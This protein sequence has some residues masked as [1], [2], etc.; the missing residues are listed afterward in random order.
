[1]ASVFRSVN[2]F[3]EKIRKTL[4]FFAGPATRKEQSTETC[5]EER[6]QD[7]APRL[8]PIKPFLRKISVFYSQAIRNNLSCYIGILY[9]MPTGAFIVRNLAKPDGIVALP[10]A[11]FSPIARQRPSISAHRGLERFRKSDGLR[12]PDCL[13]CRPQNGLCI[14]RRRGPR[15]S[16]PFLPPLPEVGQTAIPAQR[17]FRKKLSPQW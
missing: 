11:R 3:F 16:A 10:G 14:A 1:V 8:H 17:S 4:N 5:P 15:G 7:N 9:K 2:T 13:F 12:A 6:R